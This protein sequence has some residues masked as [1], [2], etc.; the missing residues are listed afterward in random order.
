MTKFFGYWAGSLPPVT[1]LH[2]K[3]FLYYHPSSKYDL[4]LD[5][6]IESSI[7]VE[8]SWIRT[9]HQIEIHSF[10]LESLV[11]KYVNPLNEGAEGK[12]LDIVRFLHRKKLIRHINIDN[13]YTPLFKINYKHSS[14]LFTY[15]ND[16]VYRGDLARCIIPYVHYS[17]P[18]LYSDL[19]VCFLSNLNT[20]CHDEGFVYQWED[21][22]F[23]NSAILYYPNKNVAQKIL[24][25][26]NQ[27]E[28]FRPWHLFKN[29]IC[30]SI[31]L[32]IYPANRFD[33]MWGKNTLLAGDASKFFRQSSESQ[34]MTNELFTKNYIANHWHNNWKIQIEE[35]SPYSN[36]LKIFT[37]KI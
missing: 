16:F 22:D 18:C 9:H 5:S 32:K 6:D 35:N 36:L 25:V 30:K 12:L 20:I 4:W 21:Y 37:D 27:I 33:A 15:K 14:P 31:G 24:E 17:S 2:F 26:G 10:S 3:S 29:S 1:D 11:R 13:Y 23:A 19:D 7:P 28:S 34:E 8:L